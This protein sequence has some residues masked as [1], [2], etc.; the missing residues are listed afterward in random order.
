[1]T[2]D[3]KLNLLIKK[4]KAFD[5]N[6]KE[7]WAS[8]IEDMLTINYSGKKY[9][10]LGYETA[11]KGRVMDIDEAIETAEKIQKLGRWDV[12]V[13][14]GVSSAGEKDIT[15][16]KYVVM[17]SPVFPKNML[18]FGLTSL[19]I[20]YANG[21]GIEKEYVVSG[22]VETNQNHQGFSKI[23]SAENEEDAIDIATNEAE[24]EYSEEWD[25]SPSE[26]EFNLN[27]RLRQYADGG[28]VGNK[29]TY[30]IGGL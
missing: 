19:N 25:V 11:G 22:S 20:K 29:F 8:Y 24:Q 10:S 3:E 5:S 23:V 21:G 7:D 2:D 26:L 18:Q 30:S 4:E 28:G 14:N 12:I 27:V 16:E 17:T 15:K 13:K 9:Y 1:M 6:S